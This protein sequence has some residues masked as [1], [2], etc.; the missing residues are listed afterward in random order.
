MYVA[1]KGVL[2]MRIAFYRAPLDTQRLTETAEY[3]R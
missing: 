1:V 2:A 3:T